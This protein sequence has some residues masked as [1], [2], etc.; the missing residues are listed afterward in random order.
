MNT[1]KKT[2]GPSLPKIRILQFFDPEEDV[3]V[4]H[5][6]EFDLV[7][8]GK[9]FDDAAESLAEAICEQLAFAVKHNC[10]DVILHPAPKEFFDR[11]ER[12]HSQEL[13]AEVSRPL[14]IGRKPRTPI[15]ADRARE[16]PL[17]RFAMAACPA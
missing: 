1:A 15:A 17:R 4:A 11:W 10:P 3:H 6:L 7:G 8:T 13:L 2:A 14:H 12:A 5:A 9:S 16:T